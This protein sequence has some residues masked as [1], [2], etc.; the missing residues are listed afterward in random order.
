LNEWWV[1]GGFFIAVAAAQL[2]LAALVLAAPRVPVLLAGIWGTV[3]LVGIY[4]VSRTV[5]L[6]LTPPGGHHHATH[7][8]AHLPTLHAVGSGIPVLPLAGGGIEPVG[9]PDLLALALEM[10]LVIVLVS[11][12]PPALRRRTTTVM[13]GLGVAVWVFGGVLALG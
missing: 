10:L 9:A 7:A 5:G 6:P 3:G 12:L 4:V 11:R 2:A 13:L 8:V 1:Y